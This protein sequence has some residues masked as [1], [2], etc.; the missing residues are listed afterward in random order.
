LFEESQN[1]YVYIVILAKDDR[2]VYVGRS[3]EKLGMKREISHL[4]KALNWKKGK[5]NVS[6][7]LDYR[8]KLTFLASLFENTRVVLEEKGRSHR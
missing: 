6:Y 7:I 3:E 1:D 4:H 2:P 5:K 8:D